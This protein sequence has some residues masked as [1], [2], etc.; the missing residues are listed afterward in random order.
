M[1]DHKKCVVYSLETAVLVRTLC[2]LY[3]IDVISTEER[4]IMRLY[5]TKV[6]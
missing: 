2:D 6:V 4:K 1:D 5:F 3:G